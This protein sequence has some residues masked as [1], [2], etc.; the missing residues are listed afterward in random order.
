[1]TTYA[2]NVRVTIAED[3]T[4]TTPRTTP[5]TLSYPDAIGNCVVT[6]DDAT[7]SLGPNTLVTVPPDGDPGYIYPDQGD[8]FDTLCIGVQ[9]LGY[10]VA[11]AAS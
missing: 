9:L 11:V 4:A 6:P 7:F 10:Q 3:I 1:M 8:Q 2:C 5:G